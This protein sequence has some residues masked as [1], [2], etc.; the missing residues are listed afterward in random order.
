M[1]A[2]QYLAIALFAALA[3]FAQNE[4]T[5][6]ATIFELLSTN[7]RT[8]HT[9][10]FINLLNSDDGY[11]PVIDLL[12]NSTANLTV[13]VP[14]DNTLNMVSRAYRSYNRAHNISSTSEYPPAN[15][16]YHNVTVLDVLQYHIVNESFLLTNLTTGNV[17]V[18]FSMLS[19]SSINHYI[20]STLPLL[21]QPNATYE[22]ATNQTWLDTNA[23]YLRFR[24]VLIPPLEPSVVIPKVR[25]VSYLAEA[26]H[27]YPMLNETLNNA[28]NFT[29][30]APDSKSFQLSQAEGMNND[31]LRQLALSHIVYGLYFTTN[32]TQNATINNGEFNLTTFNNN[33]TLPASV[34]ATS[35]QITLNGTAKVIRSNILFN[36]G[37]M[38]IIDRPLNITNATA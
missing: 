35:S 38:H 14:N 24:V 30:F 23:Q 29:I 34:N 6:N 16:S 22:N 15:W 17:T 37:I 13:F 8:L 28:T 1:K 18:A 20:N 32:F 33:A 25:N 26:L 2:I 9:A 21:I 4:T 10:R 27:R 12:S 11:R 36:N 19:N 5:P 3:V 31:T 7:N